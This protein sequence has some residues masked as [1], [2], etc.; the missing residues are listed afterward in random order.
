MKMPI[1][2]LESRGLAD[3]VINSLRTAIL[4]G[5]FKPGEK[6]DQDQ[7]ALELKVSR[8]PIREALKVLEAE[9]FIEI[10]SYRG[11]FVKSISAQDIRAVYEVRWLLEAEVARQACPFLPDDVITDLEKVLLDNEYE[12]SADQ[13]LAAF[14][15]DVKLH[16]TLIEFSSNDLIKELL[17]NLNHRIERVR[18]FAMHQPR[19][20]L[21]ESLQEHSIIVSALRQRN[22]D[23]AGDAMR[24]HLQKSAERIATLVQ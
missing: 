19:S 10:Q 12:L 3:G 18:Y 22:A 2:Q 1:P 8:T 17:H 13:E 15:Q 20:Y 6:L 4:H 7:I 14:S 9:G 24:K 21:E 11:A 16:E 23:G 5:Y